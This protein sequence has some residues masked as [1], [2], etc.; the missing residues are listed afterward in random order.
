MTVIEGEGRRRVIIEG[1]SP[2][3]DA[4][5]FP[6]KRTVGDHVRVEADIF[7]D[8][9]DAIAA[10]L[11]AHRQGQQEWTEIPMRAL[12]QGSDR[13]TATFRVSEVGRYEFKVQA[14]VDHFETWHR[15]LLKRIAAESDA[16][17]DYL[18][19]AE[20]VAAAA[21]RATG[22]DTV[23]LAARA[24]VL[25]SA[26][27]Q[28]CQGTNGVRLGAR[29]KN[30]GANGRNAKCGVWNAEWRRGYGPQYPDRRFLCTEIANR[31]IK[32]HGNCWRVGKRENFGINGSVFVCLLTTKVYGEWGRA[33]PRRFHW[34]GLGWP[35]LSG[36]GRER[37]E[38]PLMAHARRSGSRFRPWARRRAVERRGDS[39]KPE[40]G[41]CPDA[42]VN[43]SAVF[44]RALT[45]V[46]G[47]CAPLTRCGFRRRHRR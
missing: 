4:G 12:G 15:D 38:S 1:V 37:R 43:L 18:I 6:V 22:P 39:V 17:V 9:H 44:A 24:S 30:A 45:A 47:F 19:G 27:L 29:Q 8:G 3:V 36:E 26:F 40:R 14:W 42:K 16:P 13:W 7:T 11:L 28:F 25:S 41:C 31:C 34:T 33:I 32:V 23:W 21:E 46:V 20:L 10:S 5:R 2:T 35:I